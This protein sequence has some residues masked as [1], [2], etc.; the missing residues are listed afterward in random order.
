MAQGRVYVVAGGQSTAASAT[1]TAVRITAPANRIVRIR[2]VR[3]S[4]VTHGTSEQ[5]TLAAKLA[6][7]AG[8]GGAARTPVPL[9]P[10][11]GAAGSTAESGPTSEPT[12]TGSELILVGWNSLTGRDLF[13][14]DGDEIV[15]APSGIIG[16][17]V[18]SA[19]GL[20][21]FTP[22]VEVT[23]EELG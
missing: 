17:Y 13:L 4:Q 19:G 7:A 11:Q 3:V 9:Q 21:T 16:F 10:Q 8:S 12:Y 22:S 5:Y 23:F 14:P 18:V 1:E 6:S 20:T 2:R 15:V